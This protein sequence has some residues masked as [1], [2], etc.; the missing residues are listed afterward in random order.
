M[1]ASPGPKASARK[2][3]TPCHVA[4]ISKF[5]AKPL[6]IDSEGRMLSFPF[7]AGASSQRGSEGSHSISRITIGPDFSG[8]FPKRALQEPAQELES[9][10]LSQTTHFSQAFYAAIS[11]RIPQVT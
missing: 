10:G 2:L 6:S 9:V 3:A 8:D 7:D 11:W 5:F 1:V 4:V